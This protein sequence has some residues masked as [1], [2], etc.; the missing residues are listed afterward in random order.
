VNGQWCFGEWAMVNGQNLIGYSLIKLIYSR[1]IQYQFSKHHS[2]FTIAH[3][4][5]TIHHSP[6]HGFAPLSPIVLDG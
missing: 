4:P 2:L 1:T 6:Q 5:F 3:S